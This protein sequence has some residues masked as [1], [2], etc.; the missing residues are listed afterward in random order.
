MPAKFKTAFVKTTYAWT[1]WIFPQERYFFKCCDCG[2]V[3][4]MKFKSV[5]TK[6]QRKK[7]NVFDVIADLPYALFSVAFKARRVR[8]GG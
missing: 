7:A 2:L 4:E 1:D 3:H 8:K 6:R 5:I